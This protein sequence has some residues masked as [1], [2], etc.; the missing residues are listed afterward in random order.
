MITLVSLLFI[1]MIPI[2]CKITNFS[3]HLCKYKAGDFRPNALYL[4]LLK[5]VYCLKVVKE[6]YLSLHAATGTTSKP[7]SSEQHIVLSS[8][9]LMIMAPIFILSATHL[10]VLIL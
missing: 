6:L 7:C 9:Y 8:L 4:M 1:I 10:L 5:V 3:L 2:D